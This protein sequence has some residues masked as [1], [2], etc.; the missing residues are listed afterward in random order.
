MSEKKEAPPALSSTSFKS[1]VVAIAIALLLLT[2]Y[3]PYF[4]GYSVVDENDNSS[5]VIT[6]IPEETTPLEQ[7]NITETITNNTEETTTVN[8][9]VLEPT[10]E[11]SEENITETNPEINETIET[12]ITDTNETLQNQTAETFNETNIT[13]IV[14]LNETILNETILNETLLN[15]TINETLLNI[16]NITVNMTLNV[17]INETNTTNLTIIPNISE[18][19]IQGT[20][21]VGVPV[22]WTKRIIVNSTGEITFNTSIPIEA[23]NIEI[24]ENNLDQRE[25]VGAVAAAHARNTLANEK[26][27]IHHISKSNII[28]GSSVIFDEGAGL[29]KRIVSYIEQL[30]RISGSAVFE[31]SP[32]TLIQPEENEITPRIFNII[33]QTEED[34]NI[35][36][37]ILDGIVANQDE[38]VLKGTNFFSIKN[39]SEG[40]HTWHISCKSGDDIKISE[41]NS[42]TVLEDIAANNIT[43]N[44]S[45]EQNI[46]I[47][48]EITDA[49]N[50]SITDNITQPKIYEITYETP[51]PTKT[52]EEI[53]T[54][55]KVIVISSTVHYTNIIASTNLSQDYMKD[56]IHLYRLVNGS[57]E[58]VTNITY[59]DI[60]NDT[61]IDSIEWVVPS[62][63][64]QTYELRIEVLN[65]QS[66]PSLGGNWTVLFNTVGKANLTIFP[67]NG[68][69]FT[70]FLTDN[71]ET[72][73]DLLFSEIS[74]GNQSLKD[75]LMLV[76][77]DGTNISY[78]ALSESDSLK[79]TKI[80]IEDYECNETATITNTEEDGGH[81]YLAF[82]FGGEEA[83]AENYVS[84]LSCSVTTRGACTDTPVM[85]LSSQYNAHVQLNNQSTYNYAVCC[86]EL[87]GEKVYTNCSDPKAAPI[88]KLQNQSNAHV[89]KTTQSNYFYQVCLSPSA[90]YNFSCSYTTSCAADQTCVAS[91]SSTEES[92]DTNLMIGDCAGGQAYSTKICCGTNMTGNASVPTG[93]IVPYDDYTV[94]QDVIFC[95]GTYYLNDVNSDGIIKIGNNS[96]SVACNGTA[97]VGNNV[98]YGFNVTKN[99]T[100]IRGC[101][102][103]NYSSGI[104]M[105]AASSS[106]ITNNTISNS[107]NYGISILSASNNN[108]FTNNTIKFNSVGIN[109]TSSTGN[110]FYYNNF[111]SS[112]SYHAKVSV[113]GN[114]FNT[115]LGGIAQGNFWDDVTSLSIFDSNG[116][117][118]GDVGLQYPYNSAYSSKVSAYV[119]DWGPITNKTCVDY[120]GD[121]F[122]AQGTNITTCAYN[123]YADCNDNNASI[124]PPRNDLPIAGNMILCNGTYYV[125]DS[126]AQN[127]VVYMASN[128]ANLTCNGTVMI[129][130]G[131]GI[132]I[133]SWNSNNVK[134]KDCTL[135]NY[136]QGINHKANYGNITNNTVANSTYQGI[137]LYSGNY[138]NVSRNTVYN[139]SNSGIELYAESDSTI[140]DNI[141][142]NNGSNNGFVISSLSYRIYVL[143]NTISKSLVGFTMNCN[144]G[145]A[146]VLR[147]NTA[148][149]NTFY[150][151]YMSAT[152][153]DTS[154]YN[155]SAFNNSL[156]GFKTVDG[157]TNDSFV[158][159]TAAY[160]GVGF[161]IAGASNVLTNNIAYNN[162]DG[163]HV[164][165]SASPGNFSGNKVYQN[166]YGFNLDGASQWGDYYNNS[167]YNNTRY[168]FYMPSVMNNSF[169]SNLV[170]NHTDATY[171][172]G[173][174]FATSAWYNNVSNNT[175]TN[176]RI[177]VYLSGDYNTFFYNNFTTSSLHHAEVYS[178]THNYFNTTNGSSCGSLC[179]R[180]NYWDDVTSLKIYD[181][182]S[183]GFGD[184][185]IQYPYNS[186]FSSKVSGYVWDYGP[187]TTRTDYQ[188]QPPILSTPEDSAIITDSRNPLYGWLNSEHTLSNTVT[189]QIQVDDNYDFGSPIIDV[190]SIS[191]SSVFTYYWNSNNLQF[192]TPYYWHIRAYDTYYYSS[193][194]TAR[195]FTILPTVSVTQPVSEVDFGNMCVFENQ[196]KCDTWPGGGAGSHINDTLDNYPPP[197]LSENNGNLKSKGKVYSTNLWTSV[198]IIPMPHK[199]YQYMIG[200]D[201]SGS[202]EWA[203]DS[204]WENMTSTEPTAKLAYY[205][206]KWENS[207]DTFKVHIRLETPT[208]QP[209]GV[210]YSTTY[211]QSEQNESYY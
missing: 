181:T 133:Y 75:R 108:T 82:N 40:F 123:Q 8:E 179:A 18:E 132:G 23:Q 169:R 15:Q 49:I 148:Y 103:A 58:Q 151:F 134:I 63:S 86:K 79:A 53:S 98:G 208:D 149:N 182:N 143:N 195:Q 137:Y 3:F 105:S 57:D 24:Y 129:G 206:F 196:T 6:P 122:G 115:T 184:A 121:G 62:L 30:F 47:P 117:G 87:Y 116:D 205:G 156:E 104:Y 124:L 2:I 16:T 119:T 64:N 7:E 209:S 67:T 69:T 186:T 164:D 114:F 200:V 29:I 204:G 21:I 84:N 83:Y 72:T 201:K 14:E 192:S 144:P 78:T 203:L 93:C 32:I 135:S 73:D 81:H 146:H 167:V 61:L 106:N 153:K 95:S 25:L 110:T 188:M 185:G 102:I 109:I 33:Y 99:S 136:Y 173:L 5:L 39:V 176:N 183:D 211:V 161:S 12:N 51:A 1:T 207:S 38:L 34:F 11:T 107:T 28:T 150:G 101:L 130:N 194:S 131:S 77:E 31:Q 120:D 165:W 140:R 152:C 202:Y 85:Y 197:Y 10:N 43:I 41:N 191:E 42:F 147:N 80:L 158:N 48:E 210:L 199:Y 91:I 155:N 145:G 142:Y 168:G 22:N 94:M 139:Y 13:E 97:I 89:E 128:N 70:E 36:S 90:N 118:F 45:E 159:N 193:Y 52:E 92:L 172:I 154:F 112:T 180:G 74:C 76:L 17:T 54:S 166:L 27:V 126:G 178:Y 111:T 187:F 157:S 35:C 37:L 163:I 138:N 66:Y 100:I 60:D 177:G 71:N 113:S 174:D 26:Y 50:I 4:T 59:H 65:V 46:T 56:A 141:I 160:N 20:A 162:T 171:G 19:T 68:T 175:I 125:N 55:R 189:Y 96:F 9:T 190:G 88:L 127:G 44:N 198:S 170:A